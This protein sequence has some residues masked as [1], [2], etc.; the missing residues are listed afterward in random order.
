MS[1]SIRRPTLAGKGRRWAGLGVDLSNQTG[2]Y[3]LYRSVGMAPTFEVDVY[4]RLVRPG[5]G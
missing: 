3:R 2:A 1:W 5:V 4:E